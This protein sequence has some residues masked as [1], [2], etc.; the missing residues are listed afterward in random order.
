MDAVSACTQ[1]KID[2]L[3]PTCSSFPT[4]WIRHPRNRRPQM[5]PVSFTHQ[6]M[7]SSVSRLRVET[8]VGR[9]MTT[10]ILE[11]SNVGNVCT[12]FEKPTYS[13]QYRATTLWWCVARKAYLSWWANLRKKIAFEDRTSPIDQVYLVCTQRAVTVDEGTIRTKTGLFQGITTSKCE[14]IASEENHSQH[15]KGFILEFGR[16]KATE[17]NAST[18]VV[19]WQIN[20]CRS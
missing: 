10:R 7:R 20:L 2:K 17:N 18:L 11:R 9:L 15:S 1:V 4:I 16:E 12:S 6:V 8:K 13:C 14:R 3:I 5:T 19:T